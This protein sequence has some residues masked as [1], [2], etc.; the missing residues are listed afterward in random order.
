MKQ[1]V[2]VSESFAAAKKKTKY[3]GIGFHADQMVASRAISA[4]P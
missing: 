2:A 1:N 4:N 3:A